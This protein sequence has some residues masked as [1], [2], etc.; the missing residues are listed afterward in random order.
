MIFLSAQETVV[1]LWSE[2]VLYMKTQMKKHHLEPLWLYIE[3]DFSDM[4]IIS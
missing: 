2:N 1:K 3:A 4:F